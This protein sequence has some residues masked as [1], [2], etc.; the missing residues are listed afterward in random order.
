MIAQAWVS[1]RWGGLPGTYRVLAWNNP[2]GSSFDDNIERHNGVGLS[3]EQGVTESLTLFA[4]YGR[5]G[6]GRVRFDS[7]LT[8]GGELDGAFFGR[9]GDGLGFAVAALHTSSAYA[10]S[11]AASGSERIAELYYRIQLSEHVEIT[12]SVQHAARPEGRADAKSITVW[13]VRG[14]LGF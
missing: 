2:R 7:A 9:A 13:G 12:P 3:A 5:Q 10:R 1:P 4:R 6:S 11:S 8:L 14:R